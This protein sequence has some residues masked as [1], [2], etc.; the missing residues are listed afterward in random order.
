MMLAAR[1]G[2][3]RGSIVV[4]LLLAACSTHTTP[5]PAGVFL[6]VMKNGPAHYPA[7]SIQGTISEE[8]GCV[9]LTDIYLSAE[10]TSPSPGTTVLVLWPR[11]TEFSRGSGGTLDVR[12]P[13]LP[14]V[15]SGGQASLGGVPEPSLSQAQADIAA[16]IPQAC[17]ADMYWIAAPQGSG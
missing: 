3:V 9:L 15:A 7:S 10:F 12:A 2:W 13:G 4:P 11:G 6:P 8:R 1:R 16:T 14:E 17:R 5:P